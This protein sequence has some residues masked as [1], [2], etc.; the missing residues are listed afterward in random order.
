[1]QPLE[2][3]FSWPLWRKLLFRFFF[4]YIVIF[5]APWTWLDSIPGVSYVTTYWY[6]LMDWAVELSNKKIFHVRDVL[7]PING[8]G[9]TS[10]GWAQVWMLISLSLVG[11]LIWTTIDRKAKSYRHL[12]YWLCLFTR[13]YVSLIAFSY[14]II[15]LFGMQMPFPN[16]SQLA[17]PLGDFLPMRLSWMFMGYSTSYQFFSGLMEVL[18]AMLLLYRRT[19]T[20]GSIVATGV[21]LNVM[22]MNFSYDIPVKIYSMHLVMLCI[23]LLMNE[24]NR[25]I[26]FLILNKPADVCALYHYSFPKKWMRISRV[27][28]KIAFV[29]LFAGLQFYNTWGYYKETHAEKKTGAIKQAIYDIIVF[30]KNGDTIPAITTDTLRWQNIVLDAGGQG[31]IKGTDTSFRKIYGRRYFAYE[32]DTIKNQLTFSKFRDNTKLAV[33]NFTIIDSATLQL[34][35]I[36]GKDSLYMVLKKWNK[37]FQLAERQFHWLSEYN[38]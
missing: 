14:G 21:F 1:M 12:Q 9:D 22:M 7:V 2:N 3:N 35:G 6:Q 29:I 34:K 16:L 20:L 13:Y 27:V 8:S 37:N 19:A 17:T 18:A 32:V 4:I 5:I 25:I 30:A 38:R 24:Y 33:F 10:Y 28:L 15:K 23:F 36:R 11:C 31:S 26:C